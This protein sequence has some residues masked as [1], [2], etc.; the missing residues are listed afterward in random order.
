[1]FVAGGAAVLLPFSAC[2]GRDGAAAALPGSVPL[3]RGLLGANRLTGV[4]LHSVECLLTAA[5]FDD[6]L[7]R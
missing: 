3:S 7:G 6:L 5:C 4:P 1:M 2:P